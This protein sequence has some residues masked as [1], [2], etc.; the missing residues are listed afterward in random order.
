MMT[1]IVLMRSI[2]IKLFLLMIK[3]NIK[4][5]MHNEMLIVLY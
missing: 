5:N 3:A 4:S 2:L 1:D